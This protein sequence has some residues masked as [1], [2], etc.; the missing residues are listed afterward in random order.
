LVYDLDRP[1]LA[2][3]IALSGAPV[4]GAVT[5]DSRKLYLPVAE[6]PQLVVVDGKTQ[7]VV[8]NIDLP[9]KPLVAIVAGG[10]GVCH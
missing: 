5:A 8:A 7:R 2:G 4:R 9:S 3:E 1:S 10:W 6:P